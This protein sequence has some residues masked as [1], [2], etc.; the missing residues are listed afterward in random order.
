MKSVLWKG[1]KSFIQVRSVSKIQFQKFRKLK[2]YLS[3]TEELPWSLN[4]S[5]L[6]KW[7]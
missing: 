6:C 4:K 5:D 7:I 2:S 1:E 3:R